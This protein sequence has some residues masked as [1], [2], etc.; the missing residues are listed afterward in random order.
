M[1]MLAQRLR[2]MPCRIEGCTRRR[3]ISKASSYCRGHAHARRR[4]GNPKGVRVWPKQYK[5][6]RKA[7]DRL[8][9]TYPDHAG[10]R[11]AC[12]WIRA[13]L[14]ASIAGDSRQPGYIHAARLH[15]W[16]IEP[17]DILAEVCALW[18]YAMRYPR[19]LPDDERLTFAL[20]VAMLFRAPRDY[21]KSYSYPS[22]ERRKYRESGYADRLAVGTHLRMHLAPLFCNV[23]QAIEQQQQQERD[24]RDAYREPFTN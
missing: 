14:D 13:W 4:Y 3:D 2:H 5:A 23:A 18:V 24:A 11:E 7:V 17:R 21:I 12:A 1:R 16:Q 9:A 15:R 19:T 10:V 8:F 6:E 22:G 20:A